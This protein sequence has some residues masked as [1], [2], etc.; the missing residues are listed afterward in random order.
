MGSPGLYPAP[1]QPM[2]PP[3]EDPRSPTKKPVGLRRPSG[4]WHRLRC[5]PRRPHHLRLPELSCCRVDVCCPLC[6][7]YLFAR[8]HDDRGIFMG[9]GFM[10]SQ[11]FALREVRKTE[12]CMREATA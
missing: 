5:P 11:I 8:H 3:R 9:V 7:D 2:P 4:A 12:K 10:A 6:H 1:Y